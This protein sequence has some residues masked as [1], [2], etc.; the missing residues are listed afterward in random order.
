MDL[1]GGGR[2]MPQRLAD[3]VQAGTGDCLVTAHCVTQVM[4]A[5]VFNIHHY[6]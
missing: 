1:G 6:A 3:D 2:P 5:Q 4:D